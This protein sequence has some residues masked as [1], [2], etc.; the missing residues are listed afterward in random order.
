MD[1]PALLETHTQSGAALTV[2]ATSGKTHER[3]NGALRPM[4]V[5]VFSARVLDMVP[6]GG[7]QDIK[8]KLIPSL[9]RRGERVLTFE[10]P[11]ESTL[12]VTS[13]AS[14]LSVN[15][16]AVERLVRE[17][18]LG[19]GYG[20]TDDAWI[21]A[22]AQVDP[23]VRFVG[24][25]LV[26]P[27]CSIGPEAVIVGPTTIGADCTI[28][29]GAVISRSAIWER[30]TV[31]VCAELDWCIL[32]DDARVEPERVLRR[33]MCVP[34]ARSRQTMLSRLAA[35]LRPAPEKDH[36]LR[37]RRGQCQS[38]ASVRDLTRFDADP[39]VRVPAPAL[40]SDPDEQPDYS[41]I[42]AGS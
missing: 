1:L 12:R 5:Y 9:Y 24:P 31:G 40:L 14:Y 38:V 8:E 32:T 6:A 10:V 11:G 20:P 13:A 34:A 23:T 39:A 35:D 41:P 26:G 28:E 3:S 15:M 37:Q 22:S 4:G 19:G 30:C 42:E 16:W 29:Q 27:G 2:V 7:Y 36:V 21:H 17:G 33:T 18:A 25:V